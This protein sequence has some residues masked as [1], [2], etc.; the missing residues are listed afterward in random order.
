M[1]TKKHIQACV[2]GGSMYGKST[3]ASKRVSPMHKSVDPK[4]LRMVYDKY[5]RDQAAALYK[6][7]HS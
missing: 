3:S 1:K 5:F 7:I 2:I 4:A 6:A